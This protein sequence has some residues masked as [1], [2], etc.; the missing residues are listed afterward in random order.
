MDFH[1]LGESPNPR[2]SESEH[3]AC[4]AHRPT[5][6]VVEV[7]KMRRRTTSDHPDILP[8]PVGKSRH[9][10]VLN[11]L[12]GS[13]QTPMRWIRGTRYV[14]IRGRFYRDETCLV[15]PARWALLSI[16]T[17]IISRTPGG[18]D[19]SLRRVRP[20]EACFSAATKQTAH[21]RPVQ[22]R[23]CPPFSKVERLSQ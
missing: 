16:A 12:R 9:T 11:I 18:D 20:S 21:D 5:N 13:E 15:G 23:S 4:A 6:Q 8:N 7:E 3:F 17:H 10:D 2:N 19:K 14:G 1:K 22:R